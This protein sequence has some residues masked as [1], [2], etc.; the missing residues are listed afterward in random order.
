MLTLRE[1]FEHLRGQGREGAQARVLFALPP[2]TQCPLPLYEV[3][4]MLDTWLRREHAREP[5][6]IGFVTHEASFGE[7]C[8]PRMHEV[9]AERVLSPRRSKRTRPGGWSRFVRTRRRSAKDGRS[10]STC[11]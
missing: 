10:T 6:S 5:V 1:R 8:G 7:T 2:D 4:L 11:S 3:A 9:L